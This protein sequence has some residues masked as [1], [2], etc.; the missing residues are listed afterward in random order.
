MMGMLPDM[1]DDIVVEVENESAMLGLE[2]APA[3][4][5]VNVAAPRAMAI[6]TATTTTM[7]WIRNDTALNS[8]PTMMLAQR[9]VK[10]KRAKIGPM[11]VNIDDHTLPI[12]ANLSRTKRSMGIRIQPS[13]SPIMRDTVSSKSSPHLYIF[14]MT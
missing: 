3:V 4:G 1:G 11:M 8:S 12:M 6:L 2:V 7:V 9:A 5:S 10:L 14:K 13:T